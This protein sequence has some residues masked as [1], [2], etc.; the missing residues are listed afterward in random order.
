MNEPTVISGAAKAPER[1]GR[2]REYPTPMRPKQAMRPRCEPFQPQLG[3]PLLKVRMPLRNPSQR[4]QSLG[5]LRPG[6]PLA[7][8]QLPPPNIVPI[9]KINTHNGDARIHQV[10]VAARNVRGRATPRSVRATDH[11]DGFVFRRNAALNSRGLR[12]TT[13]FGPHATNSGRGMTSENL[14]RIRC[15]ALGSGDRP[16]WPSLSRDCPT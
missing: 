1:I 14:N 9:T 5:Q 11:A 4:R 12:R 16:T 8:R 6:C 3:R 13:A 10:G 15:A 7:R 2:H